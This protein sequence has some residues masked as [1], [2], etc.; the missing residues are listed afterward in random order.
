MFWYYF[1]VVQAYGIVWL[2]EQQASLRPNLIINLLLRHLVRIILYTPSRTAARVL[3]EHANLALRARM[4]AG[5]AEYYLEHEWAVRIISDNNPSNRLQQFPYTD[6]YKSLAEIEIAQIQ[7]RAPDAQRVLFL[8]G[9]P[10]PFSAL[11]FADAGYVVTAIDHDANAVSLSQQLITL[12][13]YDAKIRIELS[14]AKQFSTY[15]EYDVVIL[16]ALVGSSAKEKEELILDIVKKS[17]KNVPILCRSVDDLCEFLYLAVPCIHGEVA[18][19]P[20]VEGK[21]INSLVIYSGIC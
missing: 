1:F 18:R 15:H 13:G 11:L 20:A 19:V 7:V 8:G 14:S 3:T 6:C 12:L 2:L 21:H 10:L 5:N 4:I 17:R 16:G 9:G